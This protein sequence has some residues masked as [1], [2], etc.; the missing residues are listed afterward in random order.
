MTKLHGLWTISELLAGFN[1]IST[2]LVNSN[3][4]SEC[5]QNAPFRCRKLKKFLGR[6]YSLLLILTPTGEGNAPSSNPNSSASIMPRFA[7]SALDMCPSHSEILDPPLVDALNL[8]WR[9]TVHGRLIW[10]FLFII[11]G[12]T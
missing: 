9:K 11:I 2:S 5:T 8:V 12:K 3:H 6:G 7:P 1:L 10:L 4:V